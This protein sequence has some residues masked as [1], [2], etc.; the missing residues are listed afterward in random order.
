MK[1]D[2]YGNLLCECGGKIVSCGLVWLCAECDW[3]FDPSM[4][5][6]KEK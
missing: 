2:E 3:E 1:I 6:G 5:D 4:C